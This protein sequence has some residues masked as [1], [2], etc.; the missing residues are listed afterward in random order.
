MIVAEVDDHY[1]QD[2]LDG[3]IIQREIKCHGIKRGTQAAR[4]ALR[5]LDYEQFVNWM[6][7]F[8]L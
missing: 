3:Y 7:G 1:K 8:Q 4:M 2:I 6:C 5:Y